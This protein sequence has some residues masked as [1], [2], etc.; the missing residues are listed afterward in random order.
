[1]QDP[2]RNIKIAPWSARTVLSTNTIISILKIYVDGWFMH[3]RSQLLMMTESCLF[4]ILEDGIKTLLQTI[5]FSEAG[6]TERA[7]E[8]ASYMLFLDLLHECEGKEA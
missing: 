1:M 8:E 7:R 2:M 6:S 3:I 5:H 4:A